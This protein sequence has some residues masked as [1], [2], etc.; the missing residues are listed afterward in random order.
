MDKN[1]PNRKI[2][3]DYYQQAQSK[4]Q[5]EKKL[6]IN[7]GNKKSRV[8]LPNIN[9]HCKTQIQFP[10]QKI[11]QIVRNPKYTDKKKTSFT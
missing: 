9:K 3:R 1:K 2:C 10:Y 8:T 7:Q 11:T 6:S 4:Q 5:S